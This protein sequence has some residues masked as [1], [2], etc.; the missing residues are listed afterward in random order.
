MDRATAS[1]LS[2][3]KPDNVSTQ[4]TMPELREVLVMSMAQARGPL[5][6]LKPRFT[7]PPADTP[8]LELLLHHHELQCMWADGGISA[9]SCL[10]Q[11]TSPIALQFQG[12]CCLASA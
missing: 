9:P 4:C 10:P 6:T 1:M 8:L 12:R 11:N 7:L 2:A 5:C 3:C